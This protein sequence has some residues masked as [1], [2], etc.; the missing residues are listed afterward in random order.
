[1]LEPEFMLERNTHYLLSNLST[2]NLGFYYQ[3]NKDIL[4]LNQLPTPKSYLGTT[5]PT[6]TGVFCAG[7]RLPIVLK[8]VKYQ[9][10]NLT[11]GNCQ[12]S[13]NHK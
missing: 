12:H 4:K 9:H 8:H 5:M 2:W 13:E 3:V 1:M 6:D 11:Q 7:G 10:F